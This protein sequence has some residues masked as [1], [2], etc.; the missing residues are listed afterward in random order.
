MNPVASVSESTHQLASSVEDSW[1]QGAPPD[2]CAA[3][4]KHPSLLADKPAALDLAY[5]E[6]CYRRDQGEAVDLETF[7]AR[8]P[9]RT[10]LR[11]LIDVE[12]YLG[13]NPAA[14]RE[15]LP[16]QP[17]QWP[18]PG[19]TLGDLTLVRELGRGTFSRVFLATEASTGDR[20]VAV[21]LSCEDGGEARTQGRLTHPHIVPIL[22]ARPDP[23]SGLQM[24]CMPFLGSATLTDVLDQVF[25]HAGV[26]P[27][28]RAQVILEA[29]RRTAG[30]NDP[31]PDH[32]LPGPGLQSGSYVDGI[33]RLAL[34]LAEALALLHSRNLCH[35]DLKP[36]NVLLSPDGCPL[37]LDFNLSVRAGAIRRVGGTVPYMAPEQVRDFLADTQEPASADPR[38]DLFSLGVILYELLT[39]YHPFGPAPASGRNEDLGPILLK[40]HRQGCRPVRSLNRQVDRTLARLVDRCLAYD[41]AGR[42][43]TALEV[44][45]V[46]RRR[47]RSRLR[48][49]LRVAALACVAFLALLDVRPLS[50]SLPA[51]SA[52]SPAPELSRQG[53]F[54]LSAGH[55]DDAERYF[56]L[57]R[58]ADNGFWEAE[59]G[60][61]LVRLARGRH[62]SAAGRVK[63][64]DLDFAQAEECFTR[65]IKTSKRQP[66]SLF[67]GS[68]H[69][70]WGRALLLR[71]ELGDAHREFSNALSL[72]RQTAPFRA[73]GCIG[74]GATPSPGG[75]V[76]ALLTA[77]PCR[78]QGR[79]LA[80]LAYCDTASARHDTA[81]IYGQQAL[82][83][84][85]TS[86]GLLYNLALSHLQR[87]QFSQAHTM[88][89]RALGLAPKHPR[90]RLLHALLVRAEQTQA[91]NR[92]VSPPV[93]MSALE[94]IDAY[95]RRLERK[96]RPVPADALNL[97]L[98]LYA[99]SL[100]DASRLDLRERDR[101]FLRAEDYLARACQA[102]CA[103]QSLLALPHIKA[104][105]PSG[106]AKKLPPGTKQKGGRVMVPIDP[107]PGPIE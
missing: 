80:C 60:L 45:E 15:A 79:A 93:P 48:P 7:C 12:G 9:F 24:V 99:F 63:E 82:A 27:P 64:A 28:R 22:S 76:G 55:L 49:L 83:A 57:A 106:I 69:Y 23:G 59:H 25:P 61:G 37:L 74:L 102:G 88:R 18:G 97:G 81:I 87:Y 53:R 33:A 67:R 43:A 1:G 105:F 65:A 13:K 19:H 26:V 6:F 75:L 41:P 91:P 107:I 40:R 17:D 77:P 31:P 72:F 3:L 56:R 30:A 51:V 50:H 101:R 62:A 20:P 47:N 90:N 100:T 38:S 2:A 14:L 89:Q 44:A 68:A 34:P 58:D 8:F 32:L 94:D 46:L 92:E 78:E 5:E 29:V 66:D 39:G 73:A 96:K 103:P 16:K 95:V 35:R 10:S 86:H 84:G 42:P 54:E 21:K 104:A 85:F 70:G 36:S 4:A 71:N 11:R 52:A 98:D